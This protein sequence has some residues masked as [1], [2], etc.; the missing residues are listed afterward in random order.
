LVAIV[1]LPAAT[2]LGFFTIPAIVPGLIWLAVLGFRLWRADLTV[3]TA[4]RVTHAV[5][6]LLAILLVVYG[7]FCLQAA[8]R[9]VEAGGGLL[10]AVGVIP[11]VIGILVGSLS[12]VSLFAAQTDAFVH[13]IGAEHSLGSESEK[14]E[15]GLPGAPQG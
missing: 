9:S 8:Q 5:L 6:G 15:D 1:L 10:G 4:M 13:T 7:W 12:A 3:R 14:A 2:F 11:I